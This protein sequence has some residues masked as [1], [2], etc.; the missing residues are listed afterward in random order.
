MS[1]SIKATESFERI[2]S[3]DFLRG[4]AILGILFINIESFA[5]PDP[6]SPW[7]FGYEGTIDYS[8]RFWV[9]FLTQGKFYTMFALLFGVGFY[10]FLERLEKKQL[11]LKAMDIYARRLLWLFVIGVI[12]AYFIW[13]GDVLY[14]YAI[15]GFLLFPFRSFKTRNLLFIIAFLSLLQ[16]VKSYD[17]TM[18]RK[19][20]QDNYTNAINIPE[21]QRSKEDVKKIDFWKK[22]T[23]KK[24][25][26]TSQGEVIKKTYLIGIQETYEHA[27]AHKGLLYYQGLLFPSLIVMILGIVLYRSEIF[28]NYQIWKN[29][30]L[31]SF[32]ILSIGLSIN[33]LRFY[34]WT[35]E[36]FEPVTNIWKGW[37]FTFPK[38]ILGLGYVLILNGIFQ[39]FLKSSKFKVISKVGRTALTNYIF[40]NT[41]LGLIFYGYGLALFN[42]FSRF[43][44]IGIVAMI[45]IIQI[46]LSWLW[47]RRFQQ[48]PLEWLWRKLT[49][50]SFD[51]AIRNK[52]E[53]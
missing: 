29:Y 28:H 16:L 46:T 27:S 9:Y 34:H 36:Y 25:P 19:G 10:I 26:D 44:L 12:H 50:R 40:Q 52:N 47:L 32:I 51:E 11:G 6:W 23:K 17:Q 35:F 45:W 13:N 42:Q 39:K 53:R 1:T 14:H 33:Y 22:Q 41:L 43:E 2:P 37:L 3:L 20:W 18:R 15:C 7:K 5:Y 30:W 8:T 49:Y 4:V 38:E 21:G 31:V 48:G 24:A